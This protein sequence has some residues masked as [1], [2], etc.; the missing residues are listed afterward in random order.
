MN[1]E[2]KRS[3]DGLVRAVV[4]HHYAD[5]REL[6]FEP[7][8]SPNV[9]KTLAQL[10]IQIRHALEREAPENQH[11]SE[12]I[13]SSLDEESNE[14]KGLIEAQNAIQELFGILA[15]IA[16][17]IQNSTS[18]VNEKVERLGN[19]TRTR[20][21]RIALQISSDLNNGSAKIEEVLPAF[22]ANFADAIGF[23]SSYANWL[24]RQSKNEA[25]R[26]LNFRK[27]LT[28]ILGTSKVG[29]ERVR[30]NRT[31]CLDLGILSAPVN[32]AARRRAKVLDKLVSSL[33][34]LEAICSTNIP[35]IDQKLTEC[36][37]DPDENGSP[38]EL[39]QSP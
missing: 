1:D 38:A 19:S 13:E 4:S 9:R 16:S 26:L 7:F 33:E 30:S 10:A 11:R 23:L 31:S 39:A 12:R 25:D 29:I 22:T 6:R 34:Q 28:D 8:A 15:K 2:A 20:D 27:N 14:E 5:W 32:H 24:L 18:K 36:G 35:L 3:G 17:E 21:N 37:I